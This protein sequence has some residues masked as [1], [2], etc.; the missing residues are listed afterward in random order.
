MVEAVGERVQR[1][2]PGDRVVLSPMV[3]RLQG[4][5]GGTYRTHYICD[6][7]DVFAA[8][9]ELPDD[10]LGAVWLSHLTAWGALASVRGGYIGSLQGR[11]VALPAASSSV[12]LAAAQVVREQGG[13]SVGL[14]TRKSKAE[15]VASAYDHVVV[16]HDVARNM[17]PWHRELK[18]IT[19]GRGVNVFFDPVAAGEY[20]N[21]EIRAL[22]EGGT[23]CIYGLLGQAGTVDVTPLIRKRG[24]M[25]GYTNDA[26]FAL[27]EGVWTA[28]CREVLNGFARGTYTQRLGGTFALDEVRAA[29]TAMERGDHIGKLVLIP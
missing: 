10:L 19:D 18:A 9:A 1:V 24:S 5:R 14:T 21:T 23:I 4:G 26:L 12:A 15:A 3:V 29:H 27:G 25:V 16:T 22:A 8:P 17:K 11:T 28:A 13:I 7:A 20:L 2:K 6:E